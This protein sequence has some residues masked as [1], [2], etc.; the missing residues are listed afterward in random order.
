M[1][2]ITRKIRLIISGNFVW[3]V[4]CIFLFFVGALLFRSNFLAIES[5][6]C[7]TQYGICTDQE[8]EMFYQFKGKNLFTLNQNLVKSLGERF[9]SNRRVF[10]QKVFP[11]TLVVVLEKK[12]PI[13]AVKMDVQ[14]RGVFL[15]DQDANVIEFASDTAL[16]VIVIKEGSAAL[17]IGKSLGEE[18]A[19]AVQIMSLVEKTQGVSQG[20]YDGN[21]FS[22]ELADSTKVFFPL[23]KNPQV[24]V[25]ALQLI[26]TRSRIDS[27]L[28]RIIDLRYSNPV[29]RF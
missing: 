19:Q 9:S 29:L 16:S 3:I 14:P 4:V 12:K 24:L 8:T 22:L 1:R 18:F 10:I 25:G 20:Y 27:K 2:K 13:V 11:N 26:L 15:V 5:I 7:K 6:N 23:D 21:V 17:V 28:P